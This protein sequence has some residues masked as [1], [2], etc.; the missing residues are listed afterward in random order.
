MKKL[1]RHLSLDEIKLVTEVNELN[2]RPKEK[3]FQLKTA[4]GE[5]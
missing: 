5:E 1:A 2:T 3:W 4:V